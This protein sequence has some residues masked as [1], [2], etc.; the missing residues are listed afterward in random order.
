MAKKKATRYLSMTAPIILLLASCRGEET[1]PI[2]GMPTGTY[3]ETIMPL[4][5]PTPVTPSTTPS[6]T[7]TDTG[8]VTPTRNPAGFE[9]KDWREPVE[10]IAPENIY[11]VEKIG[12]IEFTG[13]IKRFAWSP[14]G[15]WFGVIADRF[16]ILDASTFINKWSAGGKLVAFSYDGQLLETGIHRYNLL[17]GEQIGGEESIPLEQY[18]NSVLDA[19]FSPDGKFI[20]AGGS[21]SA[22]IFPMKPDIAWGEFGRYPASILHTSVSPDSRIVAIDYDIENFTELWDPYLRKPI[23]ILAL[24][25]IS[26]KGKPRFLKDGFSLFFTGRGTYGGTE[27]TYLQEWDYRTGKPIDVQI[28]PGLVP[29]FVSPMDVSQVSRIV[30]IGTEQG[31]IYLIPTRDCRAVQIKISNNNNNPM[32]LIAFRPDGKVLATA[33]EKDNYI[34]FWGIPESEASVETAVP[35]GNSTDTSTVCPKIPMTV[36]NST[37][38]YDWFGGGRPYPE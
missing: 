12:E 16:K 7:A 27:A 14:D 35:A 19:E 28:M 22:Q 5:S 17:S 15:A 37:P 30:A 25:D 31:N 23:R 29:E 38:K 36:E 18:P 21:L 10:V 26:G 34:E 13:R 9:L 2:I 32:N 33:G 24:K 20:A 3:S 11:R 4:F 1:P 8:T 6:L